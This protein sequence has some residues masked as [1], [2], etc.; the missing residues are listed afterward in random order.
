M[1]SSKN[2]KRALLASVLSVALCCAM[3]VG[4]TFAW[5]TDSVTSTGNKIQSGNL[6]IDLLVKDTWEGEYQS[7]KERQEAIFNHDKWEPGYTDVKYIKV[8]T[9]ENLA[10]KYTLSIIPYETVEAGDLAEVIDVYYAPDE[11]QVTGRDTSRLKK[12]GTL[13]DVFDGAANTVISDTLIPNPKE[14]DTADKEDYA[15]IVL[16]M[17]ESAGNEYRNKSVGGGFDLR[18]LA[19]QYTYEEDSFDNQ[20]D[21]N[22]V[23]VDTYVTTED[24]LTDAINSAEDGDIVA[25]TE[26]IALTAPI[27]IDKDIT[28]DGLGSA[29]ITGQTIT[30]NADVTFR[31]LTLSKPTNNNKNATLVYGQAGCENL[32]FEGCTFSDPQW[33]VMQITS[34]T[35]K[36]LTVN[37]CIFTAANVDGAPSASYGN[38]ANQAIRYIHIQ[39][40][41]S[42]N[43]E[44]DI[45]ITNNV[46]KNCDKVLAVAGIFY[47]GDSKITI[48]GNEFEDLV[49]DA[50]GKSDQLGIGWP[51]NEELKI[52]EYWTGAE[53]TFAIRG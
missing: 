43:V 27:A 5:F 48:G 24:E 33:E 29:A 41:L 15:T 34:A 32:V 4:S 10:L 8:E 46:F 39:P 21:A 11:V 44:A 12:L 7:I 22:A 13:K 49:I 16:K 23:Y 51:N 36:S 47:L 6:N 45:T 42:D 35:F 40:K 31:N 37:N 9:T 50:S 28:L 30:A 38:A 20:Y 26:D 3:L 17:Q 14:G 53:Q 25:L 2:T 18:L 1:T 52:V 19:T